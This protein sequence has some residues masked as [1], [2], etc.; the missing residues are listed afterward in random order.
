ME[1]VIQAFLIGI[2]ATIGVDIWAAVVKHGFRLPTANWGLVGRWFGHFP[3]GV[4]FHDPVASSPAIPHELAIGW[5]A[6]YCIGIVYAVAYL[7]VVQ[8]VFSAS[9]TLVSALVF[10]MV[11]LVAP[12]LIMQPGMGA[13]AFASRTPR[14]GLI[15]LVNLTMH[16]TYGACLYI[17][18]L[19]VR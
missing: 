19:L 8:F 3:R 14:P 16:V 6:H 10:G 2:I 9:P 12:W 11:T 7:G 4:F 13:G 5:V 1:F 15:R 17:G 18:W